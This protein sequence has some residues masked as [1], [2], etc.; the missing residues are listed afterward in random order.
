M[1]KLLC[2]VGLLGATSLL[3][4]CGPGGQS[5]TFTVNGEFVVVEAGEINEYMQE[6][7]DSGRITV[8]DPLDA[9]Q[10]TVTLSYATTS[11]GEDGE[12]VESTIEL[13]TMTFAS[14]D[15][16][17]SVEG[18]IDT[19]T[20]IDISVDT[21]GEQSFSGTA[22]VAPGAE[23]SIA[24]IDQQAPGSVDQVRVIGEARTF[25]ESKNK[26]VVSGDFSDSEFDVDGMQVT[27]RGSVFNEET[28]MNESKTFGPV[29]THDGKFLIEGEATEPM[30]VTA[31]AQSNDKY[32][33]AMAVVEPGAE[34]SLIAR[35]SNL[36]A[37]SESGMHEEVVDSWQESEE[38]L[39]LMDSYDVAY[40]EYQA[41]ME[42]AREAAQEAEASEDEGT[43]D[44]E[45]ATADE[46][47]A[48]EETVA[49]ATE[50]EDEEV[51]EVAKAGPEPAEG[52]EHVDTSDFE[53][54]M[55]G[56]SA[57][58]SSGDYEGPEYYKI[59]L[60]MREF[61]A[62]KLQALAHDL[63]NPM[64]ALLAIELGA[65]PDQAEQIEAYDKL[66]SVLDEQV[67]A[68]R[69]TPVR[70]R[71]VARLESQ[72]NDKS[73]IPGQ[74]APA[75]TL[76]SIDG[77]DVSLYDVIGENEYV[78]VDFWASWCGP[79]IASFPDLKK[80]HAA[81]NDDGFE[82]VGVSID[83]NQEDWEGGSEEHQLPWIDLGDISK[84]FNSPTPVSFGVGWIPKTYLI[85]SKGCILE[86][87]IR[88]EALK[89][90]LIA[91]YGEDPSL[92]EEPEAEEAEESDS[93]TDELG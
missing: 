21:G 9:T 24:I 41:E 75:F 49:E 12:S 14:A 26:F 19:P 6:A 46:T 80:L 53:P 52:C 93:D 89:E 7:I 83:D 10:V 43:T 79:C 57:G 20:T 25:T 91:E 50:T 69:I 77:S 90:W 61:Q 17:V 27:V 29:L 63:D 67:V 71:T 44:S 72:D 2:F 34:I 28:E 74:K 33:S 3:V 66:A 40:A 23:I 5:T 88:E 47:E 59:S 84:G 65:I 18:T 58:M 73:L 55:I 15:E 42:A 39:A 51:I 31:F 81:Y 86:K 22:M 30:R 92:V 76:A 48:V 16:K 68:R 32:G 56:A 4:A 1:R 60:Q 87:D 54:L 82:I 38:F 70:D 45:E 35:G 37:T 36:M 13:G 8:D 64:R 62:E 78:M 85:D 11:E